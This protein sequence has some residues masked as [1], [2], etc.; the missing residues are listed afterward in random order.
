MASSEAPTTTESLRPPSARK[1]LS[2]STE[3]REAIAALETELA[4]LQ[5]DH[6]CGI[7]FDEV[8]SVTFSPCG[9]RFVC[10]TCAKALNASGNSVR[11]PICQIE[12]EAF[13]SAYQPADL[14]ETSSNAPELTTTS[15]SQW[16]CRGCC[17]RNNFECE[18]C[19]TQCNLVDPFLGHSIGEN[20]KDTRQY[21]FLA[22]SNLDQ[23]RKTVSDRLISSFPL[24]TELLGTG[25]ST[26]RLA[27]YEAQLNKLLEKVAAVIV[28]D[29]CML[30]Q[31]SQPATVTFFPCGHHVACKQCSRKCKICPGCGVPIK[32]LVV[33]YKA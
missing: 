22:K 5:L 19:S 11:C 28:D 15:V 24:P 17:H 23:L 29:E 9:H 10:K 2:S 4:N 13:L 7:C 31:N 32:R 33:A 26:Q 21:I 27:I 18:V 25:D 12:V 6:E 16:Q 1:A 3:F 14:L 8:V 30:C 20:I